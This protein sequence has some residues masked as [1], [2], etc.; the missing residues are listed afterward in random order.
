MLEV[1]VTLVVA[2]H[3]LGANLASAGPFVAMWLQ[4]RGV[5][6]GDVAA[7]E[8]GRSIVRASMLALVVTIVL[9]LAA[10]GLV[11]LA[12]PEPFFHAAGRL[13][14][15]RYWFGIAELLFY[16]ICLAGYLWWGKG[17]PQSFRKRRRWWLQGLLLLAGTDVAYHF[18]PLFAIIGVLG[19]RPIPAEANVRF[20]T[21][22]IDPEVQA[23]LLHFAL[24]SLA[25]TGAAIM[26]IG[27]RRSRDDASSAE[28]QRF[29]VWGGR[30]A[31]VPT[32]LQ[33]LVGMLVLAQIPDTSRQ[34]LMGHD[35][36]ATGVFVLALVASVALMHRL[37][38]V[39]L[40]DTRRAEVL[41][42]L[43]LLLLTVLL[44]V[45]AHQRSRRAAMIHTAAVASDPSLAAP[46]IV[47]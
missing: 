10:L 32:V 20:T 42:A 19:T 4:R 34:A 14:M 7:Y 12:R 26:A 18:P 36:A 24:A 31:L 30:I 33:L 27:W 6:H 43:A 44:M 25:V 8:M 22:L 3:L 38:A 41:G 47:S 17:S 45:G 9:G 5:H 28:W 15:S 29:I 1:F 13:P 37:A 2:V 40:G 35:L 39:A 23:F 46:H 16:F 11:W 21:L